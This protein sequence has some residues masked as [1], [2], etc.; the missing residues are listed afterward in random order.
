M[1]HRAWTCAI[2]AHLITA[3]GSSYLVDAGSTG[4]RY[5]LDGVPS[6]ITIGTTHGEDIRL[7]ILEGEIVLWPDS[8]AARQVRWQRS[9][10]DSTYVL[11]ERELWYHVI[12]DTLF[13]CLTA[14]F[15]RPGGAL[16]CELGQYSDSVIRAPLNWQATGVG[17]FVRD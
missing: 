11:G 8:T 12:A 3:C 13:L 10:G 1:R 17:R 7:T 16:N 15:D 2:A 6:Q 4:V 5:R 14:A 9:D